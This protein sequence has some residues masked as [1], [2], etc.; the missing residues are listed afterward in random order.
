MT[1]LLHVFYKPGELFSSLPDRRRAWIVPL[2]VNCLIGIAIWAVEVHFMGFI[3]IVRQ[4][5]SAIHMSAQNMEI[6][7]AGA[8]TPARLYLSYVQTAFAVILGAL[9]ISGIL[10]A[11]SM[12]TGR[13]PRFGAML[14]M[15][16]LAQFPY[17]LI[18]LLM[19]TLILTVSP[20]PGSLSIR[21]LIATNPAAYMDKEAMAPGLY[22]LL[23]S[24]DLLSIAEI[25]LLSYGFGK[26]TRSG[27]FGGL[28]AVV[29]M[30]IVYVSC[31]MALSLL[32]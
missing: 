30:W 29:G 17:Y 14:S 2:L 18:V 9:L 31:K 15:V 19:T 10:K 7:L 5:L 4:Q 16:S 28:A 12:M 27:F 32:F 11:L 25:L 23:E 20:D 3:T 13:S 24:I 21:N 8:N 22:S 26:I 1:P 6:A